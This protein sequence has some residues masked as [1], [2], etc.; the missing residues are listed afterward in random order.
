MNPGDPPPT[1]L[2][3]CGPADLRTLLHL[4][5]RLGLRRP[6]RTSRGFSRAANLFFVS[7]RARG[8]ARCGMLIEAVAAVLHFLRR[9]F[10]SGFVRRLPFSF[11]CHG[12]RL[13]SFEMTSQA[14]YQGTG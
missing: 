10:H 1:D 12:W 8:L 2:R 13:R 11:V 6:R 5:E 3:T 7:E 4:G 9:R 14:E